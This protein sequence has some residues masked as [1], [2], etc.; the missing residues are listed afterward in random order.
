[1]ELLTRISLVAVLFHFAVVSSIPAILP[2]GGKLVETLFSKTWSKLNPNS[3]GNSIKEISLDV[4]EIK[5]HLQKIEI[6]IIFGQDVKT[7]EYLIES[8]ID[9]INK[10]ESAQR[11]WANTATGYGGDGFKKTLASLKEM[12]EGSS[13][14]FAKESIFKII[15]NK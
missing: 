3:M 5:T 9:V 11:K 1:M 13:S 14:L 12:M 7:I 8:Y 4:K 15:V 10:D 2:A 6:A